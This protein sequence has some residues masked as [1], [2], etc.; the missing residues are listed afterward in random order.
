MGADNQQERLTDEWIVGFVD[1]EGTFSV[2]L[3]RNPTAASGWQV[4]PEFVITQGAKSLPALQ[5]IQRYFGCGRIYI[6]R[7][8]DN[9]REPLYR[10]VVRRRSELRDCI[11]PFF[12]T[13]ALRT[14]KLK[15]FLKFSH[16]LQ[17]MESGDHLTETG[18][19]AIARLASQMNR[20][21]ARWQ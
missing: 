14:A 5:G 6:N 20:K 7:R 19:R 18:R 13:H 10:Y 12:E 15:D 9:H 1:G 4:F 2:S 17:L 21:S 11:I 8:T 3:I 16:I